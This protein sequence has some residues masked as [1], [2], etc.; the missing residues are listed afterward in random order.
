MFTKISLI[1]FFIFSFSISSADSGN[2][3]SKRMDRLGELQSLIELS[4]L[5]IKNLMGLKKKSNSIRLKAK[6]GKQIDIK[7][8]NYIAYVEEFNLTKKELLDRFP[9]KARDIKALLTGAEQSNGELEQEMELESRLDSLKAQIDKKY[10]SINRE[11]ASENS[12]WK[13]KLK[14]LKYKKEAEETIEFI[15]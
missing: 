12:V 14:E 5:D 4:K 9:N 7:H 6:M 10:E 8:K 13:K 1:I 15:Q 2:Y 3:F 11:T